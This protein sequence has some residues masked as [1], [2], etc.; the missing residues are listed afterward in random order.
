[1]QN[2]LIKNTFPELVDAIK[3]QNGFLGVSNLNDTAKPIINTIMPERIMV[4]YKDYIAINNFD[5]YYSF[6]DL[7]MYSQTN[8]LLFQVY[9]IENPGNVF[10]QYIPSY[11]YNL[12]DYIKLIQTLKSQSI[13]ESHMRN[14]LDF[15]EITFLINKIL[16]SYKMQY[17]SSSD[18]FS[19]KDLSQYLPMEKINEIQNSKTQLLLS[20]PKPFDDMPTHANNKAKLVIAEFVKKE[21][22]NPNII[23]NKQLLPPNISLVN[24]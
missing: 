13:P 12:Y 5:K 6:S 18:L 1:M 15:L 3:T 9:K 11:S 14:E 23:N 2:S 19:T 4:I 7:P 22:I 21:N 17:A 20:H 8:I 24:V 10:A 16:E